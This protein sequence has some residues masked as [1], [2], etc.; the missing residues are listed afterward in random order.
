M[1]NKQKTQPTKKRILMY[2]LILAACLLVIAAI[3]V[4]VLFGVKPADNSPT[5]DSGSTEEPPVKEPDDEPTVDTSSKYEF[6]S[7]IENVTVSQAHVFWHNK[8]L[9]IF[10]LHQG[11]DFACDAGTEVFATVDGTVKSV[12]TNDRLYGG[13]IVIEH[14]DGVT[15]VYK[16]V[17]PSE[18]LRAGST[19]NRGDVIGTVAVATGVE[20]ADGDHLHFEVYKND[21]IQN[22]DLYLKLISK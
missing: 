6:I 18:T 1:K 15:T 12:Y 16:F 3:T 20:N 7:P 21:K 5:I 9:N 19:V 13:M 22:P 10:R 2:Y 11:M 8:T 17:D 4:G 14:A